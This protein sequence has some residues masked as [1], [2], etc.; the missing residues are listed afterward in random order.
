MTVPDRFANGWYFSRVRI[1]IG[2][3][4]GLVGFTDWKRF[5]IYG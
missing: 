1:S 2:E 3:G 4:H 5:R